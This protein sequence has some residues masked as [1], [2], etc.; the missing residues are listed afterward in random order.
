MVGDYK[1]QGGID[2]TPWFTTFARRPAVYPAERIRTFSERP[3]HPARKINN[4]E[5]EMDDLVVFIESLRPE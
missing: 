3:P 1:L 5:R 4:S 2:S